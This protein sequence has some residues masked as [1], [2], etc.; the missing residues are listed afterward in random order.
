MG[1]CSSGATPSHR[2]RRLNP[3][4][5]H[6]AVSRG[7]VSR[8]WVGAARG[9]AGREG[10]AGGVVVPSGDRPSDGVS[11]RVPLRPCPSR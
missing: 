7:G 10:P 4:P 5:L 6:R 9:E 1:A 8:R 2:H 3:T 11:V